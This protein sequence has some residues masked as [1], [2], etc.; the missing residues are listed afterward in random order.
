MSFLGFGC[1]NRVCK[2]NFP[3]INEFLQNISIK[4]A[5]KQKLLSLLENEYIDSIQTLMLL[6][7]NDLEEF[8][9]KIG[10]IG[11]RIKFKSGLNKLKE[12]KKIIDGYT[13]INDLN[14][15]NNTDNDN[16]D[17]NLNTN[18]KI[19]NVNEKEIDP[20]K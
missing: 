8:L 14:D 7:N 2:N 1:V 13:N 4:G 16:S 10:M 20:I 3:T 6:H 15:N 9:R 11:T 17:N 5:E 12:S 18:K 19:I